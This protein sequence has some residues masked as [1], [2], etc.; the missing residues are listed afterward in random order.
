MASQKRGNSSNHYGDRNQHFNKKQ[1]SDQPPY[2]R[3]G[4]TTLTGASTS[5]PARPEPALSAA[6]LQTGLV[7]LLDRFVAAETTPMA[8]KD[9]LHHAQELRT[10]LNARNNPTSTEAQRELDEKRPN[11]AANIAIPAYIQ[12]T[13]QA[14]KD[15]PPL[16]PISEPHL[17]EAVFTHQS[18]HKAKVNGHHV[19]GMDVDYE[20]LE[21]VGDAY[22]EL[23][24]TRSLYN[25]FPHVDVPTLSFWRERLVDNLALGKFSDAYGFPDRLQYKDIYWESGS[26]AWRKVVAD[27]FEA[28]VAGVIL[29]DPVNGFSTAEKW[30]DELWAPQMLGFKE[31]VVE[32]LQARDDLLKMVAIQ[33]VSLKY[34][35]ERPMKQEQG[36]QKYF[37]GV[38][39]TGWQYKDEWLGS[40][41]GQSKAQGSVAAAADALK[42]NGVVLQDAARQKNELQATRAKDR[43]EKEKAEAAENG[44]GEQGNAVPKPSTTNDDDGES[45]SNKRKSDDVEESLDKKSKKKKEKKRKAESEEV[46]S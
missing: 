3:P 30:L 26:K 40:G 43:E 7:S 17:L 39:Y 6:E 25:R 44:T 31:K 45:Y 1:R 23:L 46:S 38:Y 32:N 42:R 34:R 29:S 9:I 13:V 10:L 16:P 5:S 33:G 12:R 21:F 4:Y 35:E 37:M 22:I 36:I 19:A 24:A 27:I 11:K 18:I 28:Y 20:R 14:S 15:L 41:E 2:G 8:D